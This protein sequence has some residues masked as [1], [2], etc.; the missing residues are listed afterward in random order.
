[1]TSRC[2]SGSMS[3]A[4]PH[5]TTKCSPFGVIGSIVTTMLSA[6]F[7]SVLIVSLPSENYFGM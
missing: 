3:G 6:V 7:D 5:D 1:M 2:L 4:P